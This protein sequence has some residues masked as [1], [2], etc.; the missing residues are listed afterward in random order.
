[1]SYSLVLASQSPRRKELLNQLGYQFSCHPADIDETPVVGE[2]PAQY[3]CRIAQ[4]KATAIARQYEKNTFILGSDTAVIINDEILGKPQS[5]DDAMMMLSQLSDC[6]HQVLTAI[7]V[8]LG[9]QTKTELIITD[10]EFK[11]LTPQEIDNY[12]Q[13]GE[14]QDKAGAYGIQGLGGQFVKQIRGSYSAVVGLPLYETAKLL[15]EF[16]LKTPIQQEVKV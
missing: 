3:V 15:A 5:K 8:C 14:P 6:T 10:V 4:E 1:M 9:D 16:G 7:S 13:T 2:T 12:W 11:A